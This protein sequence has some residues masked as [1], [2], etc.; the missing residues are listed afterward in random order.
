MCGIDQGRE[1][2]TRLP[3]DVAVCRR[4]DLDDNAELM[5][6]W[7][8]ARNVLG[9]FRAKVQLAAGGETPGAGG[10]GGGGAGCREVGGMMASPQGRKARRGGWMV[11]CRALLQLRTPL[12]VA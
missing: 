4:G 1:L 10:R 11:T 3:V 5:G 7:L 12:S 8:S 9:P 2:I 6:A